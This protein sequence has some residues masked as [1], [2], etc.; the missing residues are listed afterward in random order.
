MA[1]VKE[2]APGR[3][4]DVCHRLL[5]SDDDENN[6]ER[7]AKLATTTTPT[8]ASEAPATKSLKQTIPSPVLMDVLMARSEEGIYFIFKR[9][10]HAHKRLDVNNRHLIFK[11]S[12]FPGFNNFVLH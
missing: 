2:T 9:R 10:T 4:N 5:E 6:S 11:G 8:V 1:V 3:P 7:D 12:S